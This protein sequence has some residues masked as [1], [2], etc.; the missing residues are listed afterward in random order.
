M[1]LAEKIV[2]LRK[3]Q[4]WSQEELA[5]RLQ[6]SRQSVS[7]W[8]SMNSIPDL[9]KIVRLSQ[10]FGV[11]TDYLLNDDAQPEEACG[12]AE[13]GLRHVS[14]EEANRYLKL[15]RI[16]AGRIAGAVALCILSPVLLIVLPAM[17]S[18]SV[19]ILSPKMAA[20]VG[21]G[22]LLV[23]VAIAVAIFILDG[24]KLGKFE[25]LDK[26]PIETEYGV[27]G[28]AERKLEDHE[29][30]WRRSLV[31]GVSCCILAIVPLQLVT[32]FAG[33]NEVLAVWMVALVLAFVAAGVFL[34][35]KSSM[36]R[37]S[38]QRLLE[39]GDYTREKKEHSRRSASLIFIYWTVVT[40]VYLAWSFLTF[41]WDRTWIIWPVAGVLSFALDEAAGLFRKKD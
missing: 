29:P 18:Q 12:A 14:L 28:I 38:F 5:A 40:A 20:G 26:E 39:E 4:G 21:V 11:S 23:I 33:E 41:R 35:V 36:I 10:I 22:S 19:S 1:I 13:P 17:S 6:I 25:Y 15:A 30:C 27:A 9:D 37:G 3:Q 7:K 34:I 32:G 24:L 8:E 2:R 31:L 16:S